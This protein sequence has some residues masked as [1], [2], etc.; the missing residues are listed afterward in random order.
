MYALLDLYVR[1]HVP[2][3]NDFVPCPRAH[4]NTSNTCHQ[5]RCDSWTRCD[6][7]TPGGARC[8]VW[9]S[10]E[11]YS[12]N[13]N[14]DDSIDLQVSQSSI[15][16]TIGWS[17]GTG[18]PMLGSAEAED[19]PQDAKMAYVQSGRGMNQIACG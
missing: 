15:T 8:G 17:A 7:V 10:I 5:S 19:L 13:E 4:T 14:N 16:V 3:L 2:R 12:A 18:Q 11:F 6:G 9:N 1:I